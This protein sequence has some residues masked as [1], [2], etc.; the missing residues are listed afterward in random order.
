MGREAQ[1]DEEKTLGEM[2]AE[3]KVECQLLVEEMDLFSLDESTLAIEANFESGITLFLPMV[4]CDG[5]IELTQYLL[6][7]A[8]LSH[9]AFAQ[10]WKNADH[11]T[12]KTIH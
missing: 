5:D 10:E 2:I 9:I 4:I 1:Q 12:T 11:S 3:A 8:L 7:Q 6:Y